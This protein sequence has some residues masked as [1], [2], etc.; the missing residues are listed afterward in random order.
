MCSIT[1]TGNKLTLSRFSG[2]VCGGGG[3][4]IGLTGSDLARF[5]KTKRWLILS[6]FGEVEV[7]CKER[8]AKLCVFGNISPNGSR[9]RSRDLTQ[10]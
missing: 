8:S 10:D 2:F 3:I 7:G 5:T 9:D 1:K 4:L 6:E